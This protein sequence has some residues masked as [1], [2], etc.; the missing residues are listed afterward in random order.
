MK[1]FRSALGHKVGETM[2]VSELIEQ[3]KTY[4][5]DMPVFGTWEGVNGFIT[6]DNFSVAEFVH[7]GHHEDGCRCLLIDVEE[8]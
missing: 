2:I 3:L 7:K 1:T 4:P 8:Y 5:P 6:Q